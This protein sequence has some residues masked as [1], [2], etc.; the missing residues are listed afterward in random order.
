MRLYEH[1]EQRIALDSLHNKVKL[2]AQK[3]ELNY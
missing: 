2:E 1:T 3:S